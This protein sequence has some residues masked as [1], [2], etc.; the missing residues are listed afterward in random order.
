MSKVRSF[1]A[2][3]EMGRLG[4]FCTLKFG[5]LEPI[6]FCYSEN[7]SHGECESSW[8][9]STFLISSQDVGIVRPSGQFVVFICVGVSFPF[10]LVGETRYV[11]PGNWVRSVDDTLEQCSP[12]EQWTNK[13]QLLVNWPCC[14]TTV[15]EKWW[16]WLCCW[17]WWWP[18]T[19]KN[20]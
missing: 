19:C 2:R 18:Y 20:L 16:C 11:P 15:M 3:V 4:R 7:F 12:Y 5:L 17:W 14:Y 13:K 1:L 10:F 6:S 9:L 8:G